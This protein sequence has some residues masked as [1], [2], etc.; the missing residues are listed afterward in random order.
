MNYN[1]YDSTYQKQRERAHA[2]AQAHGLYMRLRDH[3]NPDERTH[4]LLLQAYKRYRRRL[5]TSVPCGAAEWPL[6]PYGL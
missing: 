6:F 3:H 4:R 1:T 2:V 5:F